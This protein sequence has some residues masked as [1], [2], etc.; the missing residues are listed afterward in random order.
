VTGDP[1]IPRRAEWPRATD[2]QP[3]P[4]AL[5]ATPRSAAWFL[6]LSGSI[7][8]NLPKSQMMANALPI[9]PAWQPRA[10]ISIKVNKTSVNILIL[11]PKIT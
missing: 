4:L 1:A 8:Q 10:L 3:V 6:R 5:Q 9:G 11:Y 2:E 7:I